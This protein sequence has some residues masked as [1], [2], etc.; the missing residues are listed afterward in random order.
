MFFKNLSQI[1]SY[2]LLCLFQESFHG[3]MLFVSLGG[4][5]FF[6]RCGREGVQFFKV[7]GAQWGEHQF[8]WGEEGFEKIVRW[9]GTPAPGFPRTMG[10]PVKYNRSLNSFYSQT[11]LAL[12]TGRLTN[13]KIKHCYYLGRKNNLVNYCCPNYFSNKPCK[14]YLGIT[15]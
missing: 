13:Q 10:N 12:Y 5:G 14:N 2:Y 3:R 1:L 7:G 8:W 6:F 11:V 4:E 9:R 15:F